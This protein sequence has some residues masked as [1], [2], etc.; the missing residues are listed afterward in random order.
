MFITVGENEYELS[1]KLG[2]AVSL[3]KR[4]KLPLPDLFSHVSVAE[5]PELISILSIASGS[6]ENKELSADIQDS[7]GYIDL[8]T[9]VQELLAKL[10]FSG[11]PEQIEAKIQKFPASEEQKNA[12]REM[13][14]IPISE[15]ATPDSAGND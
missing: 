13:L 10:M 2:V 8:Q 5:I 14:G 11:T 1:T 12:I 6:L 3:E 4:F 9:S 7:W 15:T